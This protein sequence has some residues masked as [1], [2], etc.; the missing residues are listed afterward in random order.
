MTILIILLPH[1]KKNPCL[2]KTNCCAHI[3]FWALDLVMV[4]GL[5]AQGLVKSGP[6]SMVRLRVDEMAPRSS[7]K[8]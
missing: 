8:R 4:T 2:L 7:S 3:T 1:R 6:S 5:F